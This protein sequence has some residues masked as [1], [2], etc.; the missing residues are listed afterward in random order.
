MATISELA[1]GAKL[2]VPH[3]VL[4]NIIFQV[5]DQNHDGY[6]SDSTTL[7]TEKIILLRCFDAKEPS[8][9]NSD[10]AN[11]GNNKYSVSNIDQWLNS[12]APAGQ[13]YSARHEY[14]APPTNANVYDG[15]NEYDQDAGFLNGFGDAFL[16][17]LKSTT[18]TVALNTVTDGGGS[19]TIT[20][21]MFLASRAEVF[22]EAEN[23]VMEGSRLAIFADDTSASRIAKVSA[24]AAAHS[25][26][27]ATE[28]QNWYWWLR[29]PHS[30]NSRYARLVYSDGTLYN[31][32][33]CSGNGGVR[34]LCN[35]DSGTLISDSPDEDGCYSLKSTAPAPTPMQPYTQ[36]ANRCG[37]NLKI[38]DANDPS[39]VYQRIDFANISTADLSGDRSYATGGQNKGNRIIFNNKVVGELT[40]STQILTQDLLCL[41][42]GGGYVWDGE[43][44]IT[45]RNRLFDRLRAFT[46]VGET[47]WQA[48]DGQVYGERLV[49][50]RVKPKIAYKRTYSGE[51]DVV[52]VDIV[53]E[54]LQDDDGRVLT[55][56]EPNGLVIG[57]Q[58][59]TTFGKVTNNGR[60]VTDDSASVNDCTLVINE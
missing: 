46:I 33:A 14:D 15:Y 21:S 60:W 58:L 26:Y 5:A 12:S 59:L 22:G 24:Y 49:F 11:N 9:P 35:L 36:I 27:S 7:I 29:T 28:N 37:L 51:G 1:V 25:E 2:K 32:I 6:P 55:R 38:C 20:R 57:H 16:T 10:R 19:E 40:L 54:L 45:F 34:P 41:M 44:P 17:A 23:G 47:V 18:L 50:H 39:T 30:S 4:G 48:A 43:T 3:G 42:T 53:F 52:G 13:W 31:L 56:G 8:N